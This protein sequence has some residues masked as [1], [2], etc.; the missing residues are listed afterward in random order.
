MNLK[1]SK[2][3]LLFITLASFGCVQQP[4]DDY[5]IKIFND[6]YDEV[7]V[8]CGYVNRSGDTIIPIGKY[9]Y[10]YTDTFRNYAIVL[11]KNVGCIAIDRNEKEL[12]KI[13]WY[14]NGP[15]F[16]IEGLFRII[17]NGKIGYANE[18]G[19][20]VIEP[21]YDCAF[22]FENGKAKVSNNCRTIDH[23]E[24]KMWESENWF[25]IDKT[26]KIIE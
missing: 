23:G 22:P 24:H 1:I 18:A 8:E 19:E 2:S 12:Y 7:G 11:K 10:C 3:A 4:K 25:F 21:Q 20:I 9:I 6:E 13:F 17:I 15:D 5:L 14:E 16:I 26:G